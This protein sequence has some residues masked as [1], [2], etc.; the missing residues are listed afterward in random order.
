MSFVTGYRMLLRG[1]LP[2]WR[3]L[4]YDVIKNAQ[5]S[6]ILALNNKTTRSIC[7]LFDPSRRDVEDL[8]AERSI[9]V[10]YETIRFWCNKFSSKYPQSLRR[11]HQD[12]SD[13]LFVDEVFIRVYG[14]WL[15][16]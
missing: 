14:K 4:V 10:S 16:P 12:S 15:Y 1:Q 11:M 6:L 2:T 5:A 13:M 8:K 9:S 3:G 7:H